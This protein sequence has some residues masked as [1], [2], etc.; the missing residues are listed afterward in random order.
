MI[1][2]ITHL[3][4]HRLLSFI[5]KIEIK[6]K[7]YLFYCDIDDYYDE[8][9]FFLNIKPLGYFKNKLTHTSINKSFK[10]LRVYIS[11]WYYCKQK[12]Y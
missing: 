5:E 11:I 6:S 10:Y 4:L 3:T 7:Q 9:V 8:K 12:I 1:S 2:Q